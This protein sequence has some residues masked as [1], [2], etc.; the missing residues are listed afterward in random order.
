M[1]LRLNGV[2]KYAIS[3]DHIYNDA[4]VSFHR[5]TSVHYS[6]GQE[7]HVLKGPGQTIEGIIR[8]P[9][10][11][12]YSHSLLPWIMAK[13]RLGL[14]NYCLPAWRKRVRLYTRPVTYT[15]DIILVTFPR[16]LTIVYTVVIVD[17]VFLVL[18]VMISSWPLLMSRIVSLIYPSYWFRV[19]KLSCCVSRGKYWSPQ[20]IV[21][22]LL[23]H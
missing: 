23:K 11:Q 15:S 3:C 4:T 7:I 9:V 5:N 13:D 22:C 17:T 14:V 18:L 6:V 19:H 2:G 8:I 10:E 12:K 16:S 21:F 1:P 20:S